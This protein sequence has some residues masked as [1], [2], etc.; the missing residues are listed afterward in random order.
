VLGAGVLTPYAVAPDGRR[1]YA[2]RQTTR[3]SA[4]VTEIRVVLNWFEELRTKSPAVR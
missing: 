1:F 3:A 2:V 4:P